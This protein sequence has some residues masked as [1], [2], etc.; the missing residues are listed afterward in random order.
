MPETQDSD[1]HNFDEPDEFGDC[2]FSLFHAF[3]SPESDFISDCAMDDEC[4]HRTGLEVL[5][6]QEFK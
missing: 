4:C 6:F 3:G 5:V 1:H 2:L